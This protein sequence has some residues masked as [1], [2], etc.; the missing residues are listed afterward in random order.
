MNQNRKNFIAKDEGF[1][2]LNCGKKIPPLGRSYRNHCKF[3]LYSLHVDREIPGD[4]ASNCHGLMKPISLESG[5]RK[6]YLGMDVIHE[7]EKCGKRIKNLL[8]EGD[9]WENIEKKPK[10]AI[11]NDKLRP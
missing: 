9:S 2:C 5:S 1:T 6:G 8:N 7:C 3:C 4:R 11:L 10:K